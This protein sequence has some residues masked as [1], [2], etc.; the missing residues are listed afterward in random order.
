MAFAHS[1]TF[2]TK[3]KKGQLKNIDEDKGT[4]SGCVHQAIM[5]NNY[6]RLK[7]LMDAGMSIKVRNH[8]NLTP[9]HLA[10]SRGNTKIVQLL[11]RWAVQGRCLRSALISNTIKDEMDYCSVHCCHI[12]LPGTEPASTR[13]PGLPTRAHYS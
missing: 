3:L 10:C 2:V 8:H 1:L 6:H 12:A 4:L 7:L 13:P 9:L 11:V 5:D